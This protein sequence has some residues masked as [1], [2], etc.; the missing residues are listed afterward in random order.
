MSNCLFYIEC[1]FCRIL[2]SGFI[3]LDNRS[4]LFQILGSIWQ[5][6]LSTER[7]I[8]LMQIIKM[9]MRSARLIWLLQKLF[10]V[11]SRHRATLLGGQFRWNFL[12]MYKLLGTVFETAA[13][14]HLFSCFKNLKKR[15]LLHFH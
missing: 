9:V 7:E 11:A 6:H 4:D 13:G 1:F 15:D 10:S 12:A 14:T 8:R 3:C 5:N 2:I